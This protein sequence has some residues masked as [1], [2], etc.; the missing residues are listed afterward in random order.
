MNYLASS[1][2]LRASL[3]R[4]SLFTVPLV[5]ALGFLS[6]QAAGSGPGNPW[7]DAL[8]KPA[9]YPPPA[10]FGI[11]WSILYVMIGIALAMILSARGAQGRALATAA[12]VVQ[13]IINLSWSPTFFALHQI[14]GAF[15]I[16]VAMAV[17]IVVTLALFWRIRPVAGMLMLPYLAWVCFAAVLTYQ[18]L[19]LNPDADGKFGTSSVV[20]VEI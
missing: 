16:T 13:L 11:V 3:L 17:A 12:F 18:F 15:W 8:E 7:F 5:V 2:Q 6:G 1:G 19:Q 4:W 10:A 14:T 20:R 9:I